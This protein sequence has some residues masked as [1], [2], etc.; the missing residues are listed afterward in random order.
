MPSQIIPAKS[1]PSSGL[2]SPAPQLTGTP[3]VEQEALDGECAEHRSGELREH[4][5]D[6]VDRVDLPQERGGRR[7]RGVEVTAADRAEGHDQREEHEALREADD[8]EV[9]AELG[10]ASGGDVKADDG[11]DYED[12]EERP[13]QLRD[14]CG[15]SSILHSQTS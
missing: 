9:G 3:L 14:V 6:R 1:L 4:V 7:D 8:R 2:M 13:D 5:D 15:Q 12:E 10:R 11:P